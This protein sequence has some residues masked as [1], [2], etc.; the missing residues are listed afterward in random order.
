MSKKIPVI[1][2]VFI[3]ALA[4]VYFVGFKKNKLPS[5]GV[6]RVTHTPN[7]SNPYSINEQQSLID[8]LEIKRILTKKQAYLLGQVI[9]FRVKDEF[10]ILTQQSKDQPIIVLNKKTGAPLKLKTRLG[11]GPGEFIAA[12]DI[13]E[14]EKLHQFT[15][16]DPRNSRLTTFEII[17]KKVEVA[18]ILSIPSSNLSDLAWFNGNIYATGLFFRDIAF[19]KFTI[20]NNEITE[21]FSISPPVFNADNL[22]AEIKI[23]LNRRS[24]TQN[25]QGRIALAYLYTCQLQLFKT[26]GSLVKT[27]SGPVEIDPVYRVVPDP[28]ESRLHFLRNKNTRFCYTSMAASHSLI[29]VLFSGRSRSEFR[30]APAR[31]AAGTVIHVFNWQGEYKGKI[32]LPVEVRIIRFDEQTN[33]FYALSDYPAP[34]IVEFTALEL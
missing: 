10:I 6:T 34:R 21:A 4:F 16:Y 9:D 11:R 27:V 29:F 23:H 18:R 14:N 15:V 33:R 25:K 5:E 24:L 3:A 13:L 26:E 20:K 32:A 2:F 28:N 12:R 30:E 19:K 17:D 7:D 1:F 22:A 8:S 31:V